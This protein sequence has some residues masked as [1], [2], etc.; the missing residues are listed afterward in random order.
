LL[1]LAL[2]RFGVPFVVAGRAL[3][4]TPEIRDLSALLRVAL[5]PYER[6]ALVVVARSPLGGLSDRALVEL[7]EP[8]R[9]LLPARRWN[10]EGVSDDG[11]RSLARELKERLIELSEVAPRLSPRDALAYAVERFELEAVLG[12]LPRGPGRFGNVGRLLQIAARQGG[13]LP[14]FSRWIDR[15]I[16]L[17]VDESEAAVF[18]D[19]DDAVRLVTVHGSKGLA[20]DVTILADADSPERVPGPPLSLLRKD[21]GSVELVVRHRGPEGAIPTKLL[22]RAMDDARARAL[23]ERQRLSYVALTRARRELVLTL[24]E[25][26]RSNTLAASVRALLDSG[27][28]DEDAALVRLS[29]R[30]LLSDVPAVDATMAPPLSA[31]RRPEA[32]SWRGAAI[33]VTALSDFATCPRRFQLLHV[34]GL[35]EPAALSPRAEHDDD[36][37][38]LG[39]AA[40]R[41]LERFPLERWGRAIGDDE[42][43]AMLAR[44]GLDPEDLGTREIARGIAGFLRSAYAVSLSASGTRVH[45]EL[46]LSLLLETDAAQARKQL[47]LF[48]R[49]P[50]RRALVKA[51]LDLVVEHPDRSL[52]IVD[53]KRSRGGDSQRYALQLATYASICRAHFDAT[54]VRVGLVHLLGRSSEPEWLDPAAPDLAKLVSDLVRA[55]YA[56][57]Y[58]P[59]APAR[60]RR[61]R[62]G[63]LGACHPSSPRESRASE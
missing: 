54:R 30:E 37:R 10:V 18:S 50:Q 2:D 52:D 21:D 51:T 24:P 49:D 53:Y 19:A 42:L 33:G 6:H 47:D 17:D 48:D 27:E 61:A 60:C 13:S 62:C 36:A 31:P 40:H 59:V 5:D 63:F 34:L 29:S 20:F 28:F 58:P 26:P 35:D 43:V 4:A 25:K 46:D 14:R 9:G 11:D 57:D 3:Y 22:A 16:E 32:A 56:S 8:G 15:Q 1:E 39:S 41:V 38:V 45:R 7:S 12:S 55:R 44:E 23:A